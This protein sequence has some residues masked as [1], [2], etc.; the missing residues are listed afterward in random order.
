MVSGYKFCK[1]NNLKLTTIEGGKHELYGYDEE[2]INFM[3]E[4]ID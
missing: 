3:L 2:I 1:K 4:N